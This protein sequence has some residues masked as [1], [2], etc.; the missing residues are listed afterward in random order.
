MATPSVAAAPPL[1]YEV[2]DELVPREGHWPLVV[3]A[4]EEEEEKV[5]PKCL[6]MASAQ[7][8]EGKTGRQTAFFEGKQTAFEGLT[9]YLANS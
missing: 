3:V 1:C 6:L 5:R 4:R 2:R 9:A 7:T 8:F